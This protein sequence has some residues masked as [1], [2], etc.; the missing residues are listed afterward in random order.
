M[1]NVA[2][3][4]LRLLLKRRQVCKRDR[5]RVRTVFFA[6]DIDLVLV[7]DALMPFELATE[8]A[9]HLVVFFDAAG[10]GESLVQGLQR[11]L[12][13]CP[14][15]VQYAIAGG[16]AGL[17]MQ[18]DLQRSLLLLQAPGFDG[19]PALCILALLRRAFRGWRRLRALHTD[20]IQSPRPQVRHIGARGYARVHDDGR[21]SATEPLHGLLKRLRF[22]GIASKDGCATHKAGRVQR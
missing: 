16:L 9:L 5:L 22:A 11:S 19:D 15:G 1:Q 18:V 13:L 17:A 21:T 2:A 8:S 12:E 6:Q 3:R 4:G 20:P 10:L 7:R 14:P